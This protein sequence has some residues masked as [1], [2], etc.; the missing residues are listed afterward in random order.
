[1]DNI[2]ILTKSMYLRCILLR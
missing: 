2:I 1:M